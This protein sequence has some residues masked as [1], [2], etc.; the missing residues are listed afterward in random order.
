MFR[1]YNQHPDCV[2][3]LVI[4]LDHT[5]SKYSCF[6]CSNAVLAV[7]NGVSS[8]IVPVACNSSVVI[9]C[10]PGTRIQNGQ[11]MGCAPGSYLPELSTSCTLCSAG[12]YS[13]VNGLTTCLA[14][15][16]GTFYSSLGA[17]R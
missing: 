13:N 15:E 1:N 9:P 4:Q 5:A 16:S 8:F 7:C 12:S 2:Y 11:C 6:E 17:T 3:D 10:G 14:C